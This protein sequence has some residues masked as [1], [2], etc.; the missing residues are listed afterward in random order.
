[1]NILS[2]HSQV[3]YRLKQKYLFKMFEWKLL[4]IG[5][6]YSNPFMCDAVKY[7]SQNERK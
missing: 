1:M 3:I 4:P 2:L 5:Q 7:I 6:M